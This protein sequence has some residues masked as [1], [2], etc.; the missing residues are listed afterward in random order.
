MSV[1]TRLGSWTST[2][3]WQSQGVPPPPLWSSVGED[4]EGSQSSSNESPPLWWG[5]DH[6]QA[7]LT[8]PPISNKELCP[9]GVN[10][11]WLG[12]L[13]CY[14]HWEVT[15]S[16]FLAHVCEPPGQVGFGRT[17][18]CKI[19][20]SRDLQFSIFFSVSLF[21]HLPV[22]VFATQLVMNRIGCWRG[23]N[24]LIAFFLRWLWGL[25]KI[26]HI[27]Y[28]TKCLYSEHCINGNYCHCWYH[29]VYTSTTF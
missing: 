28:L 10:S 7:E 25:K 17:R 26:T 24:M 9:W 29:Q 6:V 16:N 27:E 4:L 19:H 15:R 13:N 3:T 22:L 2:P 14:L 23:I 18:E 5:W 12:H 11:S 20:E 1:E 8:P 21:Y